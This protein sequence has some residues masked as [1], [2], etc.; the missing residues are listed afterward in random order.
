MSD[1]RKFGGLDMDRA[2]SMRC[3]RPGCRDQCARVVLHDGWC[4]CVDHASTQD[5][6]REAREST[7]QEKEPR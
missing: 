6:A 5:I 1:R 4:S 2:C 7:P 3:D